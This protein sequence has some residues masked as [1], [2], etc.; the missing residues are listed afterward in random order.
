MSKLGD[1][2]QVQKAMVSIMRRS[3]ENTTGSRHLWAFKSRE[4]TE[5][6]VLNLLRATPPQAVGSLNLVAMA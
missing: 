5:D 3:L 1:F 6:V 4:Y 2:V